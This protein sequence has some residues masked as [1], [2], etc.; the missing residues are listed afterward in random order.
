MKSFIAIMCLAL[1]TAAL[2][3]T[4][5]TWTNVSVTAIS[6]YSAE[7]PYGTNGAVYAVLSAAH[8]SGTG[9]TCATS[10]TYIVVDISNNAGMATLSLLEEAMTQGLKVNLVGTNN[11]GIIGSAETLAQVSLL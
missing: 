1:P 7:G 5:G 8:N 3:T 11:C 9:P 10:T 6:A 4:P 2:A